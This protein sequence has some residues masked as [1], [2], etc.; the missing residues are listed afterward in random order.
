MAKFDNTRWETEQ[1][2]RTLKDAAAIQSSP[3]RKGRIKKMMAA[4]NTAM[5]KILNKHI[6]DK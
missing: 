1:D 4:D 6:G 2:I 3:K 5:E